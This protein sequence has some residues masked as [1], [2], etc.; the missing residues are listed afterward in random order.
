MTSNNVEA[1][2]TLY[3]ALGGQLTD[4]YSDIAG[5][6]AVS[7]YATNPDVILA[8]AKKAASVKEA[9]ETKELPTV[10]STDNNKVL[11]V[12]SGKWQKANLPE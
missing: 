1:L 12:V 9:A 10:T 5:G 11:T 8:I 6:V 4:T 2:K 3:V 7:D